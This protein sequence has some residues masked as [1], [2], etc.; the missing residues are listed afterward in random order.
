VVYDWFGVTPASHESYEYGH[1][2]SVDAPW[3]ARARFPKV[4]I[5]GQNPDTL[6]SPGSE[7]FTEAKIKINMTC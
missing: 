5:P 6:G 2:P 3:P 4:H 7:T 1:T